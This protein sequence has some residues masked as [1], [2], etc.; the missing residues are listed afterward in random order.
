M[1]RIAGVVGDLKREFAQERLPYAAR[2]VGGDEGCMLQVVLD[3]AVC[4]M[5]ELRAIAEADGGGGGE[6]SAGVWN[7]IKIRL[8][9]GGTV[10]KALEVARAAR[11]CNWSIVLGY[12]EGMQPETGDTFLSD[13]AVALGVG[14]IAG[15][16]VSSG[17]TF[18]VYNRLLDILREDPSIP[19]AGRN[20]RK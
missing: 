19:F 2:G 16:G 13:L 7:A 15:G 9:K 3:A 4:S 18:S 1:Q 10:S 17:E 8:G 12:A 14:Q 11:A 5:E 20:Y 6:D